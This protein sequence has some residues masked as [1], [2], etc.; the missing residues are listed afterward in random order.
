MPAARAIPIGWV[1]LTILLLG[2]SPVWQYCVLD[3]R[4]HHG[5]LPFGWA[6][7]VL[8]TGWPVFLPLIAVLLW[9]FPD[10]RLPPGRWR[11]LSVALVVVGIAA[12]A[13]R[14]GSGRGGRR[15]A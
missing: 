5:T 7:V 11:R 15:Q 2:N 14:F 3:Y 10:G 13:G 6:A 1:L 12:R 9:L 8:G 4:M